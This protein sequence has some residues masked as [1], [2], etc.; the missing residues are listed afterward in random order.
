V[1]R[2]LLMSA[3]AAQRDAIVDRLRFNADQGMERL[4]DGISD[5]KDEAATCGYVATLIQ[6]GL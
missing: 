1:V 3:P 6:Q 4:T 2:E 5:P